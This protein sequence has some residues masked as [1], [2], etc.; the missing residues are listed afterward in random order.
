VGAGDVLVVD[1]VGVGERRLLGANAIAEVDDVSAGVRGPAE[2]EKPGTFDSLG[3]DMR[4]SF[5]VDELGAGAITLAPATWATDGPRINVITTASAA[6]N[7]ID[8]RTTRVD[9]AGKNDFG[10]GSTMTSPQVEGLS[11]LP[12]SGR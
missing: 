9:D 12:R 10:V 1:G 11:P 7:G 6:T 2:V 4:G 5:A 8:R 3:A